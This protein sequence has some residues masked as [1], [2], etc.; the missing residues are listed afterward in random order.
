MDTVLPLV[1][2]SRALV[3]AGLISRIARLGIA[4]MEARK[5]FI[6]DRGEFELCIGQE[7]KWSLE[8]G[9]NPK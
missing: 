1:R 4:L 6:R 8:K 7:V 3:S 9:S 2:E 5:Y